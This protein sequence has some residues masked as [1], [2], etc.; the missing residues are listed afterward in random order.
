M[1]KV[2]W[3]SGERLLKKGRLVFLHRMNGMRML[4]GALELKKFDSLS[5]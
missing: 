5:R 4:V 3:G 1:R 2:K